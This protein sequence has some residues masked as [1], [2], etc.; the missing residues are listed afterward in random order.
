M[1]LCNVVRFSLA[2]VLSTM[3]CENFLL[4][5]IPSVEALLRDISPAS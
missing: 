2:H 5:I 3:L 4:E 1:I